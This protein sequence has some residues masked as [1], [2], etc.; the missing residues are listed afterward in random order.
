MNLKPR[1]SRLEKLVAQTREC[2][3]PIIEFYELAEGET[4]PTLG[5]CQLC[6][7]EHPGRISFIEIRDPSHAEASKVEGEVWDGEGGT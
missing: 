2:P 1:L 7:G 6:G 5:P 4:P 3:G